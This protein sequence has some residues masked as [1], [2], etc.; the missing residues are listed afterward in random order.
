MITKPSMSES[1]S[2][3]YTIMKIAA[4]R[5]KRFHTGLVKLFLYMLIGIFTL[6]SF[7]FAAEPAQSYD[8]QSIRYPSMYTGQIWAKIGAKSSPNLDM[9]AR[10]VSSNKVGGDSSANLNGE[11]GKA[12]TRAVGNTSASPGAD[13]R[14]VSTKDD[15]SRIPN[16]NQET[17]VRK[18][19][20]TRGTETKKRWK[21]KSPQ[22]VRAQNNKGNQTATLNNKASQP[23][24]ETAINKPLQPTTD[25][26][27]DQ[28]TSTDK[29]DQPKKIVLAEGKKPGIA[30]ADQP[31][32]NW[33][34]KQE[35]YD[36]DCSEKLARVVVTYYFD[37]RETLLK[38]SQTPEAQWYH[39]YPGSFEEQLYIEICNPHL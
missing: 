29:P 30:K 23:A 5:K 16:V 14:Q 19:E 22:K 4:S 35:L 6:P 18:N 27:E 20:T 25:N 26:K 2:E 38:S 34:H 21:K 28:K 33:H 13:T 1:A 12:L 8:R 37:K 11:A 10:N 39:I 15:G 9:S 32:K 3:T 7:A 24:A 31:V 36:I 17:K